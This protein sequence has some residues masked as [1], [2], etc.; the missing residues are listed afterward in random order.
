MEGAGGDEQDMVGA[1][2]TVF[3]GDGAAFDQWQ[4]VTLHPFTGDI[5]ALAL[6][7]TGDFVHFVE[8]DNAVLLHHF[9]RLGL[10]LLLVQQL[11]GLL[12]DQLLEGVLDAHLAFLGALVAQ[13]LEQALQL[14]GHLLHARGGHDLH[15]HR[16][17]T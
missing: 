10:D 12:V 7:A 3:G 1:H 8:K 5:G 4:Q 11:G 16:C 2:H 17:G 13:V 15:P 6:G 14:V 9:D